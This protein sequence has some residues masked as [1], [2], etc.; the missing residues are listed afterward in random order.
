MAVLSKL[1]PK[2]FILLEAVVAL[3]ILTGCA[4]IL[5]QQQQQLLTQSNNAK[6][7]LTQSR[8]MYEEA[9]IILRQ[10]GKLTQTLIYDDQ[11]Y[12]IRY[13]PQAYHF[14]CETDGVVM[15]VQLEN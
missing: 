8:I 9:K 5:I 6:E 3:T 1:L 10:G 11:S 2:A 13:N 14:Y 7:R 4:L 15:E 12:H